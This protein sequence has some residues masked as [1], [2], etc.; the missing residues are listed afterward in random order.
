M[1]T[2][3]DEAATA[4][5]AA[6]IAKAKAI[7]CQNEVLFIKVLT[8]MTVPASFYSRLRPVLDSRRLRLAG[9]TSPESRTV[10]F[11]KGEVCPTKPPGGEPLAAC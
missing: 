8:N 1:I 7:G 11:P 9:Q 10:Y 3:D 5:E 6:A 2:L 4:L